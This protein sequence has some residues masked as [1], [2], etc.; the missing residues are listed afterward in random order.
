MTYVKRVRVHLWDQMVLIGFALALF[1]SVFDSILYIFMQYDVDFFQRL[2]GPDMSAIWSRLTILC[3]FAI[4]GAHAQY[5][6][7]QRK[8]VESALRTSEERYRQIIETTPDGYFEV[9]IDGTFTYVN[10]SMCEILGYSRMEIT[11]MNLMAVLDE[12]NSRKVMDALHHV[13]RTGESVTAL[14]WTLTRQ[15]GT[16]RYVE[17]SISLIKD[18]K[19]QPTGYSGFLRDVTE[20]RRAQALRQA[21]KAA[22]AANRS[23]S[24]FLAN[25]SHEIR[26]P[27]NSII[28]LIELML[29]TD[30]RPDQREDL[31][32]V[33][34]S[35]YAL[36]ALINNLLDF[37]KIEA[38]KFELEQAPFSIRE[39]MDETMRMM[40]MKTQAKGLELA[41]RVAPNVHDRLM[42]DPGRLRQVML[43]LIENS[44]KFTSKGEIVVQVTAE[45]QTDRQA[46]LHIGV[47]DTG[48]GIPKEKQNLIFNAFQQLDAK[49]YSQYG[50]TGLGLAVSAQLV[51]LMGGRLRVESEP[52]Q[53]SR[54]GFSARFGLLPDN[55][56][57]LAENRRDNLRG[58]KVLVVDDNA[59]CLEIIRETLE[60]WHMSPLPAAGAEEA[61]HILTKAASAG[62]LIDL[63]LIDSDMPAKDGFSL[64]RWIRSENML[65]GRIIMMLTFPHLKRKAEFK[66]LNIKASIVKP[67]YPP[68]LLDAVKIVLGL[69]A[70]PPAT[71]PTLTP[72]KPMVSDRPLKILVAEDTPF[73][74][75]FIMRLL[76]KQ[77]YHAA[78]VENGRQVIEA[79][80]RHPFDIVLMDVQMPEMDGFEATREI[81]RLEKQTGNHI[82][83]IAMTAYAVKGD[84]ERCL[85]AGMD[86]YVS[87]PISSEKL[88][89]AVQALLPK[90]PRTPPASENPGQNP[91][92]QSLL[93]AFDH[94]RNL[95]KE[96][97]DIFAGDY[98]AMLTAMRN[99]ARAEDAE[100]L[101]RTAH[102]LKG[103]L[104]NFQAEAAAAEAFVLEQ[105]GKEKN[106]DGISD[107]V[108]ALEEKIVT[109]ERQLRNMISA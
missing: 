97:V 75:T 5:T 90:E 109:L 24:R 61:R 46:Y 94:D 101:S 39:F 15:G 47:E 63:A 72:P 58:L 66:E 34:S 64:A 48:I 59:T 103:M 6:I 106:F 105:K 74:Q 9:D 70:P 80:S 71:V 96:L 17:S 62:S 19:G 32:V 100:T 18:S 51:K 87:K 21:K 99:A 26:T 108:D 57:R 76:E 69:K 55:R 78:L 44:F 95:F 12:I 67:M 35:S 88:F 43:N 23:K 91:D 98:P 16:K 86:E 36:L 83:I 3:L 31:D 107:A 29:E 10:D 30:L 104:R 1:Y 102:S 60:C 4:F 92:R 22:E 20:R 49:T 41:F 84:R 50:G 73:N 65:D 85:A 45:S 79:L 77:G 11:G 37:S 40:A 93:K 8:T 54:F 14:G 52:G 7:N 38:G 89:E 68:E 25:M 2:L 27:L 42:G 28:G 13:N 56:R 33:I 82:P 81:R 53:G